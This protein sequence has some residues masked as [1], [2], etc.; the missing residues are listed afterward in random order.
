MSGYFTLEKVGRGRTN[1]IEA[2]TGEMITQLRNAEVASWVY[3]V[4]KARDEDAAFAIER[5]AVRIAN[6]R[7]YLEIR[8]IR[9]AD[10]GVQLSLF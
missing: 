10:R 5:R 8:R 1:I 3:R 4:T 7:E 6:A 2:A 9:E